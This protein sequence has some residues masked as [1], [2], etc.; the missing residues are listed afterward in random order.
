MKL[1][2]L[3]SAEEIRQEDLANDPE[4]RQEYLRTHLAN[5]VAIKL[6]RWRTEHQMTQ[7]KLAKILG[8]RQPNVA[9]LE[10]GEH[11]PTLDT[12]QLLSSR[13]DIHFTIDI[14]PHEGASL[15][16]PEPAPSSEPGPGPNQDPEPGF[17]V[18][19]HTVEAGRPGGSFLAADHVKKL[20]RAM[21]ESGR[22]PKNPVLSSEDLARISDERERVLAESLRTLEQA[23]RVLENPSRS[24][25]ELAK[26]I[27]N[28]V[29]QALGQTILIGLM[30]PTL[31]A[32][33]QVNF[34]MNDSL[35]AVV[36]AAFTA[37]RED[38]APRDTPESA[39]QHHD[40]R[41]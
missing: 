36:D 23:G 30:P 22:E 21:Q 31:P 34:F 20:S 13:L 29:L 37:K 38:A 8:M 16:Q 17:S 4:Y 18:I 19:L 7:T 3:Q 40:C 9:R 28:S 25:D 32:P 39:Q 10:S 35:K 24:Y 33:M 26:A 27:S 2:D 12:L 5:Q 1:S 15:R 14:D 11:V 6:I 41:R